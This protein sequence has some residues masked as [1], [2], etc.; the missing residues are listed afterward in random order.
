MSAAHTTRAVR[1]THQEGG[2][3]VHA[4]QVRGVGSHVGGD[5]GTHGGQAHQGVEG[6]HLQAESMVREKVTL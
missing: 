2:G 3:H 6:G 1:L 5:G 4:V